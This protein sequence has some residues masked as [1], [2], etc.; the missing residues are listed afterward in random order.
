MKIENGKVY[1]TVEK[2]VPYLQYNVSRGATPDRIGRE[3][4]D[5]NVA[6]P[7]QGVESGEVTIELPAEGAS[8]FFRV[9]RN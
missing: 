5:V 7:K 2:T 3:T 6:T 8:G 4:A 9:N 1:V